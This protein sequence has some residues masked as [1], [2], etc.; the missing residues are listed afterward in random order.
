MSISAKAGPIGATLGLLL[1]A[2]VSAAALAEET[3]INEEGIQPYKIVDMAIPQALTDQAGDPDNGKKV[4]VHRKKGNCLTC[5]SA[6]IPEEQF[7]GTV[8]PDLQG[9]GDRMT[10]GEMRLR[11]VNPRF[12]NPETTMIPMYKTEP[13]VQ[14]KDEFEGKP[15]L[16]AQEV[17]DVIAYLQTL[18][19]SK[20]ASQ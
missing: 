2:S 19:G 11:I 18:K 20:T 4:F 10:A 17:E 3:K 13:A 6:P 9:V 15:I 16:T 8:G 12:V 14:V 7:H 5:H 1:A